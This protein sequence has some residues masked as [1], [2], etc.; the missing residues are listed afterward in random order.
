MKHGRNSG[1][2]TKIAQDGNLGFGTA[3]SVRPQEMTHGS[4]AAETDTTFKW[5]PPF[6]ARLVDC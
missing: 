5:D 6:A 4:R 2:L 3:M 1:K